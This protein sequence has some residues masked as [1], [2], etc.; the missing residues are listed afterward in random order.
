MPDE[1]QEVEEKKTLRAFRQKCRVQVR[2]NGEEKEASLLFG[3]SQNF[4]PIGD[5]VYLYPLGWFKTD[6][7]ELIKVLPWKKPD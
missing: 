1:K 2:I 6:E 7:V 4:R 5:D 3:P